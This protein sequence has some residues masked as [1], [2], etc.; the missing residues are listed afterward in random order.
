[1][2]ESR[3]KQLAAALVEGAAALSEVA[4]TASR[5]KKSIDGHGFYADKFHDELVK[6]ER[7]ERE[8][9][10]VLE[11]IT[12]FDPAPLRCHL[13]TVKATNTDLRSRDEARK[14][15][16]L[17]CETEVLPQLSNLSSPVKP[18]SEP[19]LPAAIFA[20][21]PSYLQRTLMQANGCYVNRW[22]DAASVMI[23][24]L[25]ENLIID[26]Y[27][28]HG[29]QSEIKGSDGVYFM[30]SGLVTEILNQKHWQLQRETKQTLPAIKKLGDRAAH[31]RRYEATRQDIDAVLPGLRAAVDDLL[32][33][34]GHK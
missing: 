26:V 24:K 5:N 3:L 31:S 13:A 33:L 11:T 8:V 28:K 4:R 1:M 15:I 27:E 23:R 10:P 2:E 22:F 18:S 34:A 21:A 9:M 12:G 30:L 17:I 20:A 14:Q 7:A 29:K 25:V 19:V 6:L 32:H 16:R